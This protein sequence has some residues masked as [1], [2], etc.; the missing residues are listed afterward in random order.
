MKKFFALLVT[1]AMTVSLAACTSDTE[2]SQ[3][4]PPSDTTQGAQGSSNAEIST[5]AKTG[6]LK[7]GVSINATSNQHNQD[8]YETLIANAAAPFAFVAITSCPR[9]SALAIRVSYTS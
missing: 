5:E 9:S 4:D 3:S 6:E 2:T 7:I 8:V 1:L